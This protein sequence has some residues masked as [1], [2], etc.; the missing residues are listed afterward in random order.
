[1]EKVDIEYFK[2]FVFPAL[3]KAFPNIFDGSIMP[4]SVTF[5]DVTVVRESDAALLCNIE[6]E[7]IWIPKSQITDDS[8][9]YKADTEGDLVIT[10]WLAEQKGLV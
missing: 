8:E 6:G 1:M 7:E 4:N 10:E 5:S 3:R 2:E 9:V